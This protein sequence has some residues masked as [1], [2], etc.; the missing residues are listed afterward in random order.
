[1]KVLIACE[2]SGIIREEFRKLGH[3]AWS[4][5]LKPTEIPSEHHIQDDVLNHL[6]EGWDMMI[7]HPI[8]TFICRNRSQ[9]NEK[10]NIDIDTG[11]F[12]SLL[13][14]NID[15]ICV[16]NPVPSKKANL[17]KYTQII[18][19]YQHGHDHSKKTCLWLKNLPKLKPT[20]LVEVTYITTK[21][22]H[23]YTKGW[24]MTPRNSVARSRTFVGIAKAMA[25]QWG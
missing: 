1:M 19:P 13:N 22:G 9:L 6:E 25:S 24:Y 14:A 4:C 15:K 10:E 18:Q 23:K 3:D 17:P 2:S 11:L 20:K 12:M 21:D 5:D 7:G 8:C 16:E